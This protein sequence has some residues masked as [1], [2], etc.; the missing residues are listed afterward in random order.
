MKGISLIE[1]LIVMVIIVL[2]AMFIV[3]K[4]L[5]Y[6]Y[7]D[8][9]RGDSLKIAATLRAARDKS[10]MQEDNQ[11]WG[12]YF[13]NSSSGTDYFI[14]YKG[15]PYSGSSVNVQRVNLNPNV[16]FSTPPSSSTLDVSFNKMTGLPASTASII[17]SLINNP[18]SATISV[19]GSGEVQY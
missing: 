7:Q 12:V 2:I 6:Y 9:V 16:Q 1:V 3:P 17:I 19:L 5:D 15:A 18:T 14:L 4:F 10:R 8:Q 11:S 13:V